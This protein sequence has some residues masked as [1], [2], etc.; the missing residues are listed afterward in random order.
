MPLPTFCQNGAR[1]FS[2]IDEK[3]GGGL[4]KI[5]REGEGVAKKFSFMP[6]PTFIA[7]VTPL[8]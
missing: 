1:E 7:L 8:I 6:P 4:L 5:F 3:T 2:K